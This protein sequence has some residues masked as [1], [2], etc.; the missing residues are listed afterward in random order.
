M[1]ELIY[2]LTYIIEYLLRLIFTLWAEPG[3]RVKVDEPIAQ[4][5]TDKVTA[6]KGFL[7][8]IIDRSFNFEVSRRVITDIIYHWYDWFFF[9]PTR[10]QSM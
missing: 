6:E 7:K 5:E 4:I 8:K 3:D 9:S 10:W 1:L 2:I